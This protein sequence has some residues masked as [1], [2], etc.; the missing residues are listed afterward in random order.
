MRISDVLTWPT[1]SGKAHL[2][3]YLKGGRLT[4]RQAILA[5]CCYCMAGY[6]DGR[7]S[8]ES[9]DCALFPFMPYRKH[10]RPIEVEE[11]GQGEISA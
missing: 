5:N 2:L 7:Y 4:Q 1:S 10:S 3:T 9:S 6:A 8:C 11:D